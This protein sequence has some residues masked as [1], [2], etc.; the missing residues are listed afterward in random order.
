MLAENQKDCDGGREGWRVGGWGWG[1]CR[2]NREQEELWGAGLTEQ[3]V[4][5]PG[6]SKQRLSIRTG[7]AYWVGHKDS[8]LNFSKNFKE[9]LRGRALKVIYIYFNSA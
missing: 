5:F 7:P 1:Q 4:L 2:V 9:V 6:R 3:E 8:V